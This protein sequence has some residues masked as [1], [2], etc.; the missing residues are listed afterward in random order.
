MERK[1]NNSRGTLRLASSAQSPALCIPAQNSHKRHSRFS[2]SSE[3][4][5]IYVCK[6]KDYYD[7]P[8]CDPVGKTKD[9]PANLGEILTGDRYHD[10]PFELVALQ[11]ETCKEICT[12]GDTSEAFQLL[13][14]LIV[15][16]Y[17]VR[18]R[19]DNMPVSL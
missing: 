6:T 5:Q 2:L 9:A 4:Q 15:D 11:N 1:K 18:M 13:R 12:L 7:L 10:A 17:D 8:L 3:K 16:G 14:A 19:V